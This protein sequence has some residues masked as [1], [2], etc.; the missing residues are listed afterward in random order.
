MLNW[1][2]YGKEENSTP[3]VTA[4]VKSEPEAKSAEVQAPKTETIQQEENSTSVENPNIGEGSRAAA[5]RKARLSAVAANDVVDV[6]V[7]DGL[8]LKARV[9]VT[10]AMVNK[11]RG[12]NMVGNDS[13]SETSSPSIVFG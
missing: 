12:L 11:R 13:T 7:V 6:R 3:P 1:D 4:E 9:A 10:S 5:A 2:E 8:V